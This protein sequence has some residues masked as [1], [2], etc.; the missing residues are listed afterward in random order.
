MRQSMLKLR[1]PA[2]PPALPAAPTVSSEYLNLMAGA[3][4]ARGLDVP[5]VFS[6]ARI[7]PHLLRRR[8]ARVNVAA[9]ERA[10]EHISDRL[11]DPLFALKVVDAFPV[12]PGSAAN[13]MDYLVRSSATA[14]SALAA[15]ARY[16]PLM[17]DAEVT[18]IAV[19]GKQASMRLRT[20][21]SSPYAV[22]MI[23]GIVASRT[24]DLLGP[25]WSLERVWL[26]HPAR[27]SGATYERICGAPV[28]F[29]MPVTEMV[30]SREL[31]DLPMAEADPHLNTILTE[32]ADGLLAKVLPPP[33]PQS[34]VERL[35]H[36]IRSGLDAGD[37]TLVRLA[38]ELGMSTRTVQRRLRE[39]GLTHRGLVRKVRED[40]AARSLD[41]PVSQ[42][43]IARSLGYSGPGAFQ[44]AFKSWS[45]MTPGQVRRRK[46]S[47]SRA[48]RR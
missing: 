29:E 1:Q 4:A 43:Q 36:L 8:G 45:G 44:R 26:A 33:Q 21:R 28:Y 32:H 38:D 41:A 17:S 18:T 3:A 7:D 14:G 40:V 19:S 46:A 15:V 16:G 30:F 27:G 48:T 10:W 22:E 42:G 6:E 34:F 23:V 12:G 24:R 13:L 2:G 11:K 9:V 25:N 20:D 31:L 35:E 5:R 37:F 39:T 47:R